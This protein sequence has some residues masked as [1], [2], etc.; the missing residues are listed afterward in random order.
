MKKNLLSNRVRKQGAFTLIELSIVLVI[1]GLIV[2]GVLVGQ[3][4]IRAAEARSQISQI[5]KYNT[6]VNTFKLKYGALP[7]DI[8][9][10][11]AGSFGF[12]A[13]G[14]LIGEGDGNGFIDGINIGGGCCQVDVGETAL[15][16]M[17]LSAAELIDGKFVSADAHTVP[18]AIQSDSL[19]LY[20]PKA[21]LSGDNYV[22]VM[23]GGWQTISQVSRFGD[24]HNYFGIQQIDSV[25]DEGNPSGVPNLPVQQAYAIDQKIDD[26][27]PQSGRVMALYLDWNF[28]W[29]G[30]EY[31]GGPFTD[32]TPVSSTSCFDNGNVAGETQKYSLS[33]NGGMNRSCALLI[34]MQ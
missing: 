34:M 31:V 32:A 22:Y 1:I 30:S 26:G 28:M 27:L 19:Y 33:Q 15:F 6:A 3:D 11:K 18:P 29:P 25:D 20:M 12:A 21:K 17:D 7:G 8:P 23:T 24:S 4:L 13:R 9:E 5:E 10:P 2:G 16:W 14:A